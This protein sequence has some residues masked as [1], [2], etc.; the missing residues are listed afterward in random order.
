MDGWLERA[1]N[2]SRRMTWT[3]VENNFSEAGERDSNYE[4]GMGSDEEADG[5]NRE[6]RGIGAIPAR[7]H[8]AF[9]FHCNYP[10][11]PPAG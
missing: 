11:F 3:E 8:S 4:G 2:N 10:F 5:N 7:A 6:T 1:G 9:Y